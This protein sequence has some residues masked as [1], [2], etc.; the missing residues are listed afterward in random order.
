MLR[1]YVITVAL[2]ANVHTILSQI[3]YWDGYSIRVSWQK[4]VLHID[5]IKQNFNYLLMLQL[6]TATATHLSN[7]QC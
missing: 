2:K 1:I 7:W 3:S 4:P 5:L 6:L